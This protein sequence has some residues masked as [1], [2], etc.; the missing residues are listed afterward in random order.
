MA[1]E[2]QPKQAAKGPTSTKVRLYDDDG[3]R[4]RVEVAKQRAVA[5]GRPEIAERVH[6][7]WMQ[8]C[9]NEH[10]ADLLERMLSQTATAAQENEFQQYVRAAT[11]HVVSCVLM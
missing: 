6:E 1:S 5:T 4:R 2:N 7:V 9:V 8:S 3:I 11:E 10:L